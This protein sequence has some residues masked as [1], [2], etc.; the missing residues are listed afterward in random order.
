LF[1][2]SVTFQLN[3]SAIND[4]N[5]VY[6]VIYIVQP[7]TILLEAIFAQ[8]KNGPCAVKT[9]VSEPRVGFRCPPLSLTLWDDFGGKIA[10]L[11][12]FTAKYDQKSFASNDFIHFFC[13]Q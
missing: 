6:Y 7:G 1:N 4:I 11:D 13:M 9:I 12:D 10:G 8:T 2:G 3:I 5:C